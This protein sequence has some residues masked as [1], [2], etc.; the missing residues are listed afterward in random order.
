MTQPYRLLAPFPGAPGVGM[1][2]VLRIDDMAYIPFDGRNRDY[3]EYLAWVAEGN[4]ADPPTSTE[5]TPAQ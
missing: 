4:E 3:Q 1:Q 5:G 2:C